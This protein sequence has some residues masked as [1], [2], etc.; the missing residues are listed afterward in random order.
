MKALPTALKLCYPYPQNK[1]NYSIKGKNMSYDGSIRYAFADSVIV[2]DSTFLKWHP[3]TVIATQDITEKKAKAGQS[4]WPDMK[5]GDQH[6]TVQI[7]V[8]KPDAV[9]KTF[10]FFAGETDSIKPAPAPKPPAQ[11]PSDSPPEDFSIN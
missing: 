7:A 1:H 9:G 8:D 6:V 2:K 11:Q 3:A 5:A 10:S 4:L